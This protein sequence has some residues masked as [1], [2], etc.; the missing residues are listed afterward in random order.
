MAR[1]RK[2]K[3]RCI[4]VGGNHASMCHSVQGKE[5]YQESESTQQSQIL[6]RGQERWCAEKCP[7]DL[8]TWRPLVDFARAVL[9]V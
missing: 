7:L 9:V 1:W 5:M 2:K 3:R 8:E 6:L 4:E